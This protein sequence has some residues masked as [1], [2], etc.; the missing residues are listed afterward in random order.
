[1]IEP[2]IGRDEER[3]ILIKALKSKRSEMITITGRRRVGKTHMVRSIYRKQLD[4]EFMGA[5]ELPKEEQLENF[6][7]TLKRYSKSEKEIPTPASWTAAFNLLTDYLSSLRKRRKKVIFLDEVPWLAT[8]KSGFLGALGY[9]WN[10]WA[11]QNNVILV[12][13]GSAASWII[14]K[15]ENAKGSLHGRVTGRIR[16]EPF[17]LAETEKFLKRKNIKLGRYQI[18]QLYMTMGGIPHYLNEIEP[19]KNSKLKT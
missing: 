13:C 18:I 11:S 7:N 17:T 15:I 4:F 12:L 6:A 10:S 14:E 2:F 16:L 1:M 5:L 19:G 9:F 8:N 3:K